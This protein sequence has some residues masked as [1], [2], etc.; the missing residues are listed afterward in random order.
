[1]VASPPSSRKKP[2]RKPG[3]PPSPFEENPGRKKGR[4]AMAKSGGRPARSTS[5]TSRSGGDVD[6]GSVG[7]TAAS[8][9][10][11]AV[12]KPKAKAKAKAAMRRA[13]PRRSS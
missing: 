7:A 2:G 11:K 4:A 12:P 13:P 6:R 1:M 9:K 8:P 10:A 3:L 5:P